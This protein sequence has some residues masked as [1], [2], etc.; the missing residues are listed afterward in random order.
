MTAGARYSGVFKNSVI[1]Q[2]GERNLIINPF[3]SFT[4]FYSSMHDANIGKNY[5]VTEMGRYNKYQPDK[6][7]R[8]HTHTH[9]HTRGAGTGWAEWASAHPEKNYGGHR[10]PLAQTPS[11][12]FEHLQGERCPSWL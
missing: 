10:P 9:T 12:H 1:N 3:C 8:T 5:F 4:E 2:R 11:A 7:V 6:A